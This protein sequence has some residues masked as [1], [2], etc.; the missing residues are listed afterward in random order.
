MTYAEKRIAEV[1]AETGSRKLASIEAGVSPTSGA[2]AK[3]LA[4]PAVQE[5]IRRQQVEKLFKDALPAAVTCLIG[6]M[7]DDKAPAGAR[8]Q[9][10]KVV[11]DRTLGA[12]EDGTRKEPHEMT[13]EEIADAIGKLEAMAAE[14]AKP[15]I[16]AQPVPNDGDMFS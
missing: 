7:T 5:E 3:A 4:R 13:A 1:M 15:V 6:I 12:A 16:S 8:V 14:R 2:V 9:A 11:L 10:S